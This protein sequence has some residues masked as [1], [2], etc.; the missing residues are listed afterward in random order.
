MWVFIYFC[1]YYMEMVRFLGLSTK[2]KGVIV[3]IPETGEITTSRNVQFVENI[4]LHMPEVTAKD[5]TNE[6]NE[7]DLLKTPLSTTKLLRTDQCMI[8]QNQL[9]LLNQSVYNQSHSLVKPSNYFLQLHHQNLT[10]QLHKMTTQI[11]GVNF[12]ET[13]APVAREQ[14]FKMIQHIW[15]L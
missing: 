3:W 15:L 13:Y 8:C 2:T 9:N 11:Q 14:S 12:F 4:P 5:H 7:V 6:K 1:I 10:L